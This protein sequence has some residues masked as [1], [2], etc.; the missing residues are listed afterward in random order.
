MGQPYFQVPRGLVQI[1]IRKRGRAVLAFGL[2]EKGFQG[3]GQVGLIFILPLSSFLNGDMHWVPGS[4]P[5]MP[6]CHFLSIPPSP[7]QGKRSLLVKQSGWHWIATPGPVFQ[8]GW[9][10]CPSSQWQWLCSPA[11]L[12]CQH[13]LPGTPELWGL[14]L[15]FL[16]KELCVTTPQLL[17][18][19]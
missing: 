12:R 6:T 9:Q 11:N 5:K 4:R 17:A 1:C 14:P 7:H 19:S 3:Q 2:E 8:N 10:G 13:H 16:R 15:W 18:P